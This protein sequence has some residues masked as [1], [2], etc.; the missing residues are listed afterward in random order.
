[1]ISSEKIAAIAA[2]ESSA[3]KQCWDIERCN[4]RMQI[5]LDEL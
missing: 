4:R 3:D 2:E 1:M 5:D